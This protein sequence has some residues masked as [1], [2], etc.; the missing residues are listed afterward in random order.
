MLVCVDAS[1]TH[2]KPISQY[3]EQKSTLRDRKLQSRL[4]RELG[5]SQHFQIRGS[6]GLLRRLVYAMLYLRR[7]NEV[8]SEMRNVFKKLRLEPEANMVEEN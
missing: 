8:R 1:V 4:L 7:M 2:I 5:S 3:V 6:T